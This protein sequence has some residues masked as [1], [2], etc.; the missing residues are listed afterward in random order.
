[1]DHRDI[2]TAAPLVGANGAF[3]IVWDL[4][5]EL[6]IKYQ[7]IEGLP[8]WPLNLD[9]KE[10]QELMKDL[11]ARVVEELGE[12]YEAFLNHD[13]PNTKEE[14]ADA[15]HFLTEVL[16]FTASREALSIAY[17]S[18]NMFEDMANRYP[19]PQN[20][21]H[22]LWDV[23]YHLNIARNNLR[24]KRWKQTQVLAQKEAFQVN[25]LKGLEA[26]IG[27]FV[28]LDMSEQ[29]ILT[30]YYRKNQINHFRIKSKY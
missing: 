10:H 29:D 22:W 28:L 13:L 18:N 16:I 4:Q 15:L 17:D 23:T 9:L 1:M 2:K 5:Y 30:M 27:G 7:A 21:E 25:L 3:P 26:L 19:Q 12:A 8:T 14:L 11:I 20:I 24:N 6:L